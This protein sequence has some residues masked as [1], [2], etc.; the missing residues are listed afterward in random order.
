[1]FRKLFSLKISIIDF[2]LNSIFDHAY[3]MKSLLSFLN[4]SAFNFNCLILSV[5]PNLIPNLGGNSGS[6]LSRYISPGTCIFSF[7][8]SSFSDALFPLGLGGL[9]PF[10]ANELIL[11]GLWLLPES[12]MTLAVNFGSWLSLTFSNFTISDL[13]LLVVELAA[14]EGFEDLGR[15]DMKLMSVS[16]NFLKP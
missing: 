4:V 14:V 2:K 15:F 5:L 16:R 8:L 1:M 10:I 7:L 3:I 13:F 11:R 12:T 9:I 6:A